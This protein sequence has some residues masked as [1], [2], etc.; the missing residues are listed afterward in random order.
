M[1]LIFIKGKQK[2]VDHSRNDFSVWKA[3]RLVNC[4]LKFFKNSL[5]SQS[6]KSHCLVLTWSCWSEKTIF[7]KSSKPKMKDGRVCWRWQWQP[8]ALLTFYMF[9]AANFWCEN[10]HRHFWICECLCVCFW[11]PI[12]SLLWFHIWDEYEYLGVQRVYVCAC[13]CLD[14]EQSVA[15]EWWSPLTPEQSLFEFKFLPDG[16]ITCT[17]K[18]V[19]INTNTHG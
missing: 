19:W 16:T 8:T 11:K 1:K 2:I 15:W 13:V 12:Q 5:T 4:S 9:S 3:N 17:H 10:I 6:F 14:V 7:S 18:N